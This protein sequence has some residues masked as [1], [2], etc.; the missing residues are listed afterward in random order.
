M[1]L[2]IEKIFFGYFVCIK[3]C[4]GFEFLETNFNSGK[5]VIFEKNKKY[6]VFDSLIN[7]YKYILKDDNNLIL[8]PFTKINKKFITIDEY[9]IK[10]INKLL[11]N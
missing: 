4:Y 3:D 7:E 8:T 1:G 6:K 2:N 11:K 5:D 10:K 9:R